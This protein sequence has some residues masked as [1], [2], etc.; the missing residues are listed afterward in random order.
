MSDI[1]AIDVAARAV[2]AIADMHVARRRED[3]PP[4]GQKRRLAVGDREWPAIFEDGEGDLPH[5]AR[6]Q[7]HRVEVVGVGFEIL[8]HGEYKRARV[9]GQGWIADRPGGL[10]Q[11]HLVLDLAVLQHRCEAELAAW[12]ETKGEVAH[13]FVGKVVFSDQALHAAEDAVLDVDELGRPCAEGLEAG[14]APRRTGIDI[15]RPPAR[16]AGCDSRPDKLL[17]PLSQAAH[18]GIPRGNAA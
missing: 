15:E 11:Q 10:L 7:V 2:P 6:R 3:D 16:I 1:A 5:P 12:L 13:L 17:Q 14:L 8:A 18:A 4:V 9:P